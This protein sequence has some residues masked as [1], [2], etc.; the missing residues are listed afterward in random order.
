MS[1]IDQLDIISIIYHRVYL[2][3]LTQRPFSENRDLFLTRTRL[4]TKYTV[5][6]KELIIL[7]IQM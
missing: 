2:F 6:Q 7:K 1:D 5:T 3:L 4:I